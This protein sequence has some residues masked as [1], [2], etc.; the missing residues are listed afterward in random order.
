MVWAG[1]YKLGK[2]ANDFPAFADVAK[3]VLVRGRRVSTGQLSA[4]RE[5]Q[6][7]NCGTT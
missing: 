7:P 4:K 3:A 6:P 2:S 1:S 5:S